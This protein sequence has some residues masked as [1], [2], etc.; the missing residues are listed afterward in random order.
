MG[1]FY[2]FMTVLEGDSRS[3]TKNIAV[4]SGND[5]YVFPETLQCFSEIISIISES[6]ARESLRSVKVV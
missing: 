3:F 1:R 5:A 6:D 2:N 4:F